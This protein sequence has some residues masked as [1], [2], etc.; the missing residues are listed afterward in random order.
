MHWR[1]VLVCLEKGCHSKSFNISKKTG[2]CKDAD[3]KS[4]SWTESDCG[5]M[6]TAY[7][8]FSNRGRNPNDA[9]SYPEIKP[10]SVNLTDYKTRLRSFTESSLFI[11]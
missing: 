9:S 6:I 11:K 3:Q 4:A 10:V 7:S 8:R 2:L 5:G 1:S